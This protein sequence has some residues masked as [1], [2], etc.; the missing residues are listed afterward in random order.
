MALP[1]WLTATLNV[2]PALLWVYI[3]LGLPWALLILPRRDWSQPV[4][5][6]TLAFAFG[7]MLL[8]AWMFILGM[9]GALRLDATLIGL[10]VMTLVGLGLVWRKR[11]NPSLPAEHTPLALDEKLIII[12]IG[13]AVIIRW[14]G[15][16]FWPFTAYDALWVFGYEGRLYTLLG[17][18]P[19]H[20]DYYPQFLPLQYTFTQLVAGGINDHAARAVI[21]FTHVGSILAVHLLGSRLISRRVGIVAAALWAFYPHVGEWSR[22]GDLEI[23][24]TFLFTAAAAFFL[25]AWTQPDNANRRRHALIAGLLL[26]AALW[27]KPTA[28]AFIWGVLLLLVIDLVRLRFDWQAWR[29]RFE[30]AL[31]TGLASIPLG[32]VWYGRNIALGHN[33]IDLPS[34][35]WQTLAARSGVEF[36]WPLLALLLLLAFVTVGPV[37]S[38]PAI[39]G[40]MIGLG[41]VLAGTLPSI[42]NPQRM[43]IIEWALLVAGGIVLYCT[44]RNFTHLTNAARTIVAK[45]GWALALALPYFVTWF[46]S[47]SYHY[48]LVFAIVPLMLLPTA[49]ILGHWLTVERVTN[50]RWPV[51]WAYGGLIVLAALPGIVQPLYDNGELWPTNDTLTGDVAKYE[52]GNGALMWVVDG[53][54]KFIDEHP[55]QPLVVAAPGVDRLPFFFPLA[56]IRVDDAPT[57]LA[58]L[59]DVVYF[60][61]SSPE[62]RGAYAD[63]PPLENQVIASLSLANESQNNLVRKAWWQ[64]DGIFSYTVYELYLDKRFENPNMFHDPQE[65][66]VFGEFARFRGHGIGADTFWPGRPVYLQLYWETLTDAAEDY[67]IYV[68]LRDAAGNVHATWDGPVTNSDDGRYYSTLVWEPGEFVRD[69]RLLHFTQRNLPPVGEGYQIVIG[70]YNLQTGERLPVIIG[71]QPAGDGFTLNE[72]LKVIAEEP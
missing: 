47:Y 31:Y 5:V 30:V 15:I 29:P 18:I 33:A 43:D 51:R 32:A 57:R 7:P 69:E 63:M 35:F 49:V 56:D 64:D 48:R 6:L 2:M 26:G 22:F 13:I 3:G 46:Y 60:V 37:K 9:T 20:I 65:P 40:G 45:V 58:E 52:S 39:R 10:L 59:A 4:T 44:L 24:L 1:D 19:N 11:K 54:Q 42:M 50:W 66:V 34:A 27:T 25:Q 71:G 28:G 14:W 68:H 21:G 62:G 12:L 38:R 70:L 67:T 17:A 72:R 8:T 23:P 61:D 41:L 36:G 16:A 55:D 53:L